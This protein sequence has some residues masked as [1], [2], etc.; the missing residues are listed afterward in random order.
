MLCSLAM[1]WLWAP[2]AAICFPICLKA[3]S[4]YLGDEL[5]YT[6]AIVASGGAFRFAWNTAQWDGGNVDIALAYG[7]YERPFR[8]G[9]EALGRGFRMLWRNDK[10]HEA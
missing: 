1:V 2:S 5:D 4:D 3:V 9:V 10:L 7:D 8:Q 6:Y